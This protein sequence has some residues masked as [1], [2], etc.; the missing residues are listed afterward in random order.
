MKAA[1]IEQV[2]VLAVHDIPMPQVGEY[3]ALCQLL[4]GATCS[5]TDLHL[6]HGRFPSPLN[7]PTVLGHESV[8]RVV[9][10]GSK[11]RNFAVGD[12]VTR[13]ATLP[14]SGYDVNWGGF[15]EFGIACDHWAARADGRPESEWL[16]FR[17]NRLVPRSV[18]PAAA[19]MFTTWR[20]TLSYL[21]RMGFSAGASLLVLGSGGVGL[22]FVAQ[23]ANLDASTIAMTGSKEREAIARAA[24]ASEYLDYRSEDLQTVVNDTCPEGF[25]FIVDAVGK[26]G[27]LDAALPWLKDGGTAAIYGIDDYHACTVNPSRARGSFTFSERGYDEAET[28]QQV[29]D[30]VLRG[31]LDASLWL[32]LDNPFP[33]DRI[34]DAFTAIAERK[35]VK[36]LVQLSPEL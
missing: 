9:E 3:D 11:V 31:K 26:E 7:Y 1:V 6:I 14:V 27:M 12:T 36:A 17:W 2:G 22:S 20:E 32:D 35:V 18:E 4:Y 34:N 5:G 8:G 23:A 19:T 21:L 28:H 16:R 30:L 29:S 25:D 10:V 24:G 15:A 13:V 33:L